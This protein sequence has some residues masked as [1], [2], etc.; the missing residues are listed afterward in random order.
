MSIPENSD[1][2]LT[3]GRSEFLGQ[4]GVKSRVFGL[5]VRLRSTISTDSV[6]GFPVSSRL[7]GH[8]SDNSGNGVT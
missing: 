4:N 1:R 7:K 2:M 8:N 3:R 5:K 6:S